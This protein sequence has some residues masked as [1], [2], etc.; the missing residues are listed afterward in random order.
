MRV[1]SFRKLTP[2]LFQAYQNGLIAESNFWKNWFEQK[3]GEFKWDYDAR[4]D[5]NA[6]IDTRFLNKFKDVI[7]Q[8]KTL[9]V[10]DVGSGPISAINNLRFQFPNTEIRL[11]P[12][13]PL[14]NKY[15]EYLSLAGLDMQI[16]PPISGLGEILSD[17]GENG[18]D[19]IYSR[20]AIDHSNDPV[21]VIFQIINLLKE[22]SYAYLE[23]AENEAEWENYDGTHHWNFTEVDGHFIIWSTERR[24][25]VSVLCSKYA[26]IAVQR[27]FEGNRYKIIVDIKKIN[28]SRIKFPRSLKVYRNF[29]ENL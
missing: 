1:K 18:F 2:Q 24:I 23:H 17:L 22:G 27:I 3:G 6:P 21:V 4:T 7:S 29:A 9:K 8:R 26:S 14:A 20:N 25:D 15:R 11:F 16:T 10:M 13:D 28:S 5:S 19:L 12:I